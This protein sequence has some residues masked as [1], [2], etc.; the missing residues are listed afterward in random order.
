M[1]NHSSG[2]MGFA[3]AE[4]LYKR[5]ADVI[6]ITGPVNIQTTFKG[7]Q[8]INVTSAA[9]MYDAAMNHFNDCDIAIMSAAVADY[10]PNKRSDE[11]IKKNE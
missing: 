1:S 2:K 5:G 11:K 8:R 6:L 9:Q 3:L 10:T 4:E 7:I